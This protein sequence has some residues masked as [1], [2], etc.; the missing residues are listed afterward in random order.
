MPYIEHQDRDQ[1]DDYIEGL[2]TQ[3]FKNGSPSGHL[4]YIFST[5]LKTIFISDMRY[6]TANKILGVLNAV[7]LEFYRTQVADYEN[8][9]IKENGDI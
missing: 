5:M 7:T 3:L 6:D 2:L 4:N 8:L 1:Y 9:K